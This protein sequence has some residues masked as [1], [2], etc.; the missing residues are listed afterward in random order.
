MSQTVL[1]WVGFNLFV[2]LMLAID[3]GLLNRKDHI[4]SFKEAMR[5]S[6]IWIS[7]A[8][9]FG[10]G[11]WIFM[12][13]DL[14]L[15]FFTGYLIEES[16]SVDNLFVILMIFTY[17][18]VP[19]QYQH[20]VL[21]WG[22]LGALVM[23]AAFI[24]A[25]V[26]LIERFHW[27]IYVFGA[28]LVFTGIKMVTEK[29]KEIHPEHNPVLRLF[30]RLVPVT[31]DYVGGRFF[32]H[33]DGRRMATPLMVVLVLIETTDLI[34]AV[35]SVPAVLSV[36]RDPFIVYTSNVFAILGLRSLYF[37]L[38]GL[39]QRFHYL[40]YGLAF[41]LTFVGVKMMLSKVFHM[42]ITVAL[43]VVV[44]V[45]ALSV[46]LSWRFPPH[47]VEVADPHAEPSDT[48]TETP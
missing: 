39:M 11:V 27:M 32:T 44:G 17:F 6:A 35:D 28:L 16:L 8:L 21:F 24:L 15:Q 48:P 5:N 7:L 31:H 14:G 12:G 45:L 9:L 46:V 36:S 2:L 22:I 47:P 3:L 37:A 25:G 20:K 38:A 4:I 19:A 30:R 34:F 40:H 1:M 42:P 33:V 29:D 43:G 23:R 10:I 41:I 26:A 13:A 18:R